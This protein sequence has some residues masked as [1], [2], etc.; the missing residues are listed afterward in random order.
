MKVFI[1]QS[2]LLGILY[3]AITPITAQSYFTKLDTLRGT[4]TAERE[5]WDL[6]YYQLDLTINP[7]DSTITGKNLVR[8]E[9][10]HPYQTIQIDL[11]YP[12]T[13]NM[14]KQDG[15]ELEFERNGPVHMVHLKKRQ[16]AGQIE[17]LE[18][19]YGGRPLVAARAPWSGGVSWK[20]DANGRPFVATS[21][22]G[23]G[24][25]VWWPCK[26]HMY[27]EPDS[28]MMRFSVP[29]SLTAVGNGRLVNTS[30]N[31]GW[32]TY[33]WFVSVPIA[34]YGVNVNIGDYVHFAE[35]YQGEKGGL[36]LDYYV[37]RDHL[38][39][40]KTHFQ[41][42]PRMFEAFEHWFGPYP[43]YEDGFKLVEVPYLG[44]EH[45]SSITY[46][47]HYENGYLGRDLS[48]TGWGL[49]F[50]FII[51]HESGH[52]W[53]ANNITYQD[54]ADMWIHES[55]TNYSESLFLDYH[56][57]SEAGNA[58]V[59]GTRRNIVNDRPIIG[60][61]GVN[62]SGSGDMYYKG[63]NMLHTIRQI[64]EDDD[65]FRS[66]LRTMN[67]EFYHQTVSTEQIEEFMSNFLEIDLS[68][69]FDQYLRDTD[70]PT[71]EYVIQDDQFNYRW[72]NSV[73]HF[74]MPVHVF[75]GEDRQLIYPTTSWKSMPI[76]DS[77][78]QDISVDPNYYIG[79][80]EIQ[81]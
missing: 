64:V 22:Q 71:L 59:R 8:Y 16:E 5:W 2:L 11:Q 33:D 37:L 39:K 14:V 76:Q 35:E 29:D 21:C 63:G 49:K 65:V 60:I 15:E 52:E 3:S 26:D 45:Q 72:I 9:V 48:Q 78:A 4:V 7:A 56:F 6:S 77:S 80:S 10:L 38:E 46:G 53:F 61:Y 23:L 50:D 17:E 81:F 13:I 75:F 55:F 57:G 41:E 74:D 62:Q 30:T 70:I 28:M 40:A 51:I 68:S 36:S 34:N 44:M 12:L 31:S 19:H 79:S 66:M 69:V 18:I 43:F 42:V 58:Y 1:L 25:S 20:Q 47:N 67:A 54:I 27:D 73:P 24:A 32:T